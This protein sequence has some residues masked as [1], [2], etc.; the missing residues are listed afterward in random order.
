MR[1]QLPLH[2]TLSAVL[3]M[4]LLGSAP[5]AGASV[6]TTTTLAVTAGGSAVTT[7]SSGTVVTLTATVLAG[8]TPVTVG[9]VNF[10]NAAATNCIGLNLIATAQLTSAGTATYK[11]RPGIGSHSYRAEFVGTPYGATAEYASSASSAAALTVTGLWPSITAIAQGPGETSSTYSLTATVGGNASSAPT[12][13][14][15]FLDTSNGNSVLGSA[16]L[17]AGTAGVSFLNSSNPVTGTSIASFVAVGDFNGDGIPDLAVTNEWQTGTLTVLLGNGDGTF[18]PTST[19]PDAGSDAYAI[20]AADF[21]GDGKID[22]AVINIINPDNPYGDNDGTVTILLGNGDGTFTPVAPSIVVP[23]N[24]VS[25]A[26]GD[27]N[28]DGIPDLAVASLS[29]NTVTILLGNGDGTFT[30]TAVSP[31]TGSEPRSIAVGDFNGDGNLDLAVTNLLD[32]TVTILLG[33]G[34]GNFTPGTSVAVGTWPDAIAAGDFNGD[35]I[36]DLAVSNE[37]GDTPPPCGSVGT[38]TILLGNGD[39]TFTSTATNPVTGIAPTSIVTGDFNGD[40]IPD[41]ATANYNGNSV[42]V[43]LGDGTGNFTAAV[44]PYADYP[45]IAAV[46]DF[47][48]DGISD[49]AVTSVGYGYGDDTGYVTILEAATQTATATDTVV[50]PSGTEIQQV[51]ASYPGDS[52]YLA[53]ISGVLN[54]AIIAPTVTVTP[55]SSSITTSQALTVTVAVSVPSGDPIPTG[56]VT[57]TSGSYGSGAITLSGGSAQI[58]IPAGSL[59][60]GNDTLTVN[61]TPDASSSSVYTIAS[62]TSSTV[63]VGLVTPTVTVTLS[64]SSIT[65]TQALQVS[66]SVSG[67]PGDPPPTGSVTLTGGGY[68]STATTLSSGAAQINIPAGSLGV[69]G[70]TLIVTYTPDASSSSIYTSASGRSQVV[71]TPSTLIVPA[72]TVTPSSSSIT[73]TQALTVTVAVVGGT[74]NPT[75]TGSVTLISG[76]FNTFGITL[77]D[78]A[79]QINIPAGALAIGTDTL[80]VNYTPDSASSLFYAVAVGTSTVIVTTPILITPTVTVTPLATSIL[81]TQALQVDVSVS[82]PSGDPTPTG[83]VDL[84]SG[85]YDSGAVTLSGGSTAISVPADSLSPGNDTLSAIYTPDSA[86]SATYSSATGSS[87]VTVTAPNGS[88]VVGSISPAVETAGDATFTLTVNGSGF[89]SAST[90]YWGTS[91]LTTTFVS[92]A[93][94]TAQVPASDIA[95]S[96]TDSITVESPSPGGGT[97]NALEFEVDSSGAGSP[98]FGANTATVSPGQS[99]TYSVTLP[100]A[101]TTVTASCLNL[102]AGASCSFSSTA[103]TL[104]IATASSTPAGTYQVTLVFT[105]TVAGAASAFIFLP[106]LMLPLVRLRKKWTAGKIWFTACLGLVLLVASAGIGC[107]GGGSSGT[108]PPPATHQVTTSGVVTLTVQ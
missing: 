61:Y 59:A 75:P 45:F 105:E 8:T 29:E 86:S 102:P 17:A 41:L 71:V 83:S 77:S 36:L 42:T 13:T 52:N 15:S 78:G 79:A 101:A 88:P 54:A 27:F 55:S 43:L 3:C 99:A 80:T 91:A 96:G 7:V 47:N 94:I 22:L 67:P 92:A 69:G 48:G 74:G 82:G 10:C 33:D 51:D 32:S 60:T 87:S 89:V 9:Q 70:D 21:N 38:V 65:P 66:V 73:N 56:S 76:S 5:Q 57:L 104:T 23:Y 16:T 1:L 30:P 93:Q 25:I 100:S 24:S 6:P 2:L 72:V 34:T 4:A 44:S 53:S 50:L 31:P 95:S 98:S 46:G 62:G 85:S 28:G 20:A 108:P 18:T 49:L 90:V 35:G 14:V 63:A 106:I 68:T 58:N 64:S 81:T 37:C 103:N 11:F 39:G 97:S 40:G 12:G 26:V 19:S 107:G 84:T